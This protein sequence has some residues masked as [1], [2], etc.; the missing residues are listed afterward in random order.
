[1]SCKAE[2]KLLVLSTAFC[3][4][5]AG[6]CGENTSPHHGQNTEKSC[7]E[8]KQAAKT[9]AD[10]ILEALRKK[11]AE[12]K[13]YQADVQYIFEQPLLESRSERR[14]RLYYKKQPGGS[15]LRLNFQTLKTDDE[16]EQK[17]VEQFIFDGVWLTRIDYQIRQADFYQKAPKNKPV[18][19]FDL[20]DEQLPI[21]GFAK[22]EDLKKQ[23]DI[24]LIESARRDRND[25]SHLH[26]KVKPDSAYKDDYAA[27]DIWIDKAT[28]LP[29]KIRATS[30]EQDIYDIRLLKARGNKKLKSSIFKVEI[31]KNFTTKRV[32]LP[33]KPNCGPKG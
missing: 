11:V 14:G 23:F 9:R 3:I 26:L 16:P 17:C 22:I 18:D 29:R 31:P 27:V 6:A 20:A 1:M 30:T 7:S 19:A 10:V 5:C 33:K 25:L 8:R 4:V 21:I 24:T 12:L 32:P 15:K 13:S 2:I 28:S